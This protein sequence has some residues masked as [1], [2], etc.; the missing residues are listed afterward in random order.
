M[1]LKKYTPHPSLAL[2]HAFAANP[3]QGAPPEKATFLFVGLDANY[4]E[5]IEESRIFPRLLEYLK[6]GTHF[7]GTHEVHHPFLLPEYRGGG[8]YYH[9]TF[10][11]IGF[12]PEHANG[13]SFIEM[14]HVPTVG[15][16]NLSIEHLDTDHLL[17]IHDAIEHGTARHI[18]IPTGVARLMRES[19]MFPE[20]PKEPTDS[21]APL[22]IWRKFNSKTVYWHYHLSV[23]GKFER[24]KTD[25]LNAIGQLLPA[26]A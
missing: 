10:A 16:S 20:M 23:F 18:F 19:S 6:D 15:Q 17:R 11:R 24:K 22:K 8:R 25:Q 1:R 26:P 7:W 4:S 5:K 9:K 3:F 12:R 13:V 2:N 21:G 14:L